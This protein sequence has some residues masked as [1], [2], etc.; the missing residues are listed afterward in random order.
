MARSA[1]VPVLLASVVLGSGAVLGLLAGC[2]SGDGTGGTST[3]PG[4]TAPGSSAPGSPGASDGSPTPSAPSS[5]DP[6]APDGQCADAV[7]AVSV[8]PGDAAAG[9]VY[10]DIVLTNTGAADCVLAGYP[11][12]SV[13]G[14]DGEQLGVPADREPA[15]EPSPVT[16]AAH[17]GIAIAR[18]R[19]VNIAGGGGPLGDACPVVEGD[20]YRV[21]PPHSFVGVLAAADVP[22]CDSTTPWMTVAP[23]A[24]G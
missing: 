2:S 4:S 8:R 15:G 19:S 6:D 20:G 14:G 10:S 7:L 16:L 22:A 9:S 1:P 11:G 3:A 24:A 5:V 17:G 18:L 13:V 21:Y 23:V 12:V